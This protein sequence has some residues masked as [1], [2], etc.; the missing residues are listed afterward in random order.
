VDTRDFASKGKNTPL[1]GE[2]LKG[3]VMVTIYGGKVVYKAK[4]AKK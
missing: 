1:A 3:K 2:K 4:G